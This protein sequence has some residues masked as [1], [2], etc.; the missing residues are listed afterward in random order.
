MVVFCLTPV[1]A[2]CHIRSQ[3]EALRAPSHVSRTLSIPEIESRISMHSPIPVQTN[4]KTFLHTHAEQVWACDFLPVMDLF[5][6][7]LFAFFI[8]ELHSRKVIHVG[9]T[10]YP[11]DAWTAQQLREATT[12]LLVI[13]LHR[14]PIAGSVA[15]F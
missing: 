14:R 10:R 7:S 15:R 11:T 6:R 9:V 13:S 12:Y 2:T 1:L 3:N 5:F 8:I 4:W